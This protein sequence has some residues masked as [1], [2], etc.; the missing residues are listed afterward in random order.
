[1]TKDWSMLDLL[2]DEYEANVGLLGF[3]GD[4]VTWDG[5][6]IVSVIHCLDDD[7]RRRRRT[8]SRTSVALPITH[9]A[10]QA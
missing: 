2:T 9:Q 1:M 10:L 6:N 5:R 8:T 7:K 3:D 4:S